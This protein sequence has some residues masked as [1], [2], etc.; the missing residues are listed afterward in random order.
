ME[1]LIMEFIILF[2]F[3]TGFF[4]LERVFPE[5]DTT[6]VG[7]HHD[8]SNIGLG[9]INLIIGRSFAAFT[10]FTLA[11]F[12]SSESLGVFNILNLDYKLE[13]FIGIILLDCLNYWWHRL[14]HKISFLWKFHNIH[15]TDRLLNVSSALRFHLLE[16][17]IG[18][19]FKLPFILLIGIPVRALI[20]YEVILNANVYFHHSNI[21]INR[22]LD[23]FISNII[24]T[25]YIHRI[26][27][28]LSLKK[29]YNFSSVLIFWDKAFNSFY[30]QEEISTPKY[31]VPGFSDRRYQSFIYM[32][33]QPF[34]E[35]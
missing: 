6:I 14:V 9:A 18:Y 3:F 16:V 32:L 21:K 8:V 22:K 30:P 35:K 11:N 34:I 33:K 2:I 4:I 15:H 13:T 23:L 28:S 27:H 20:F 12:L 19:L 7:K 26:H 31:G 1:G 5:L 29:S 24:V 25:P 10:V 17:L